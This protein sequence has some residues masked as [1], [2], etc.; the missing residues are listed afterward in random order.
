VP[1]Q[2]IRVPAAVEITRG[3]LLAGDVSAA[4]TI[5]LRNSPPARN[6]FSQGR[7]CQW[8]RRRIPNSKPRYGLPVLVRS[9][10][11]CHSHPA[12]PR[13]SEFHRRGRLRRRSA[14]A[15]CWHAD[16]RFTFYSRHQTAAAIPRFVSAAAHRTAQQRQTRFK[17]GCSALYQRVARTGARVLARAYGPEQAD[18]NFTNVRVIYRGLFA[19]DRRSAP[20]TSASRGNPR[21]FI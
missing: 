2:L 21:V 5:S 16:V 13:F 8:H 12:Y 10:E 1:A 20:P 6:Q 15:P 3:G 4:I 18:L 9:T 17:A 7:L 11:L 14:T 19:D